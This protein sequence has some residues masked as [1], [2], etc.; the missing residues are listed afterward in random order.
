MSETGIGRLPIGVAVLAVLIGIFGFFV[1][2][3]GL[4]I[5]LLGVSIGLTTGATIF[6]F[7]GA[8]AGLIILLVGAVILAV[9]FGLWDQ[10]LWA[11]VLAIIV[12]LFFGAIEFFSRSWLGL[13]IVV[14][15]L[16]YLLAVSS[17]FD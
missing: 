8:F 4:L 17:H 12:L 6:G 1:L 16:V 5:L 7:T 13:I 15:L 10:E 14:A 9:A 3:A 2:I 11:L